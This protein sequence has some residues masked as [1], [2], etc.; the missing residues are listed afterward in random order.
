MATSRAGSAGVLR[1]HGHQPATR[2]R[3][4]V[5]QLAAELV[6]ALIEDG[7]VQARLGPNISSRCIYR[8]C[9]RLGQVPYLQVLNT[10]HRVVLAD[11]GRGLVQEVAAGIADAG[12]DALD[13]GFGLLPIV[14]VL[15]FAA[16]GLLRLAQ[17]RF[18]PLEAVEGRVEAAVRE[19]GEPS[20]AQVDADCAALWDGPLNLAL[21]LD[22]HEPL[23]ARL[24]DGDVLD[25][26]QHLAAVAVT[27]PTELGQE[28]AAARLIEFDLLGVGI[29]K[30]VALAFL[31]EAWE[32][33][34]FG[35]EVGIGAFQILQGLLQRMNRGIRQPGCLW[36][37]P[38]FR[39]PLAQPSVAELLLA[40]LVTFF[41]QR[42]CLVEHEPAR[43]REAAHWLLL[44]TVGHQF[45][46]EG[47][48]S[49]HGRVAYI[50]TG[51][52]IG[53]LRA[54]RYPSQS[55]AKNPVL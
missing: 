40:T 37:M 48:K 45:V 55:C 25:R 29:A 51:A 44:L 21:G 15:R 3:Q 38:P 24:A 12:M 9:R 42:Q 41:V 17:G 33:G 4:L 2:P 6:P 52:S 22:A 36:I 1:R 49:K 26:S 7:F 18:V 47:L 16:H 8:T 34:S 28:E 32:G 14:A 43:A 54:P 13:A 50:G 46:L 53:P 23:A 31:L 30:T 20:N 10:H 39:E 11:R 35:E 5:V 19:R 27:Q